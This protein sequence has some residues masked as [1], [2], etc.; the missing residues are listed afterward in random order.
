MSKKNTTSEKQSMMFGVE[1]CLAHLSEMGD[2]LEKV[3]ALMDW[4]MFRPLICKLVR[5]DDYSKGGRP[6]YDEI[7]MFKIILLQSWNNMSDDRTE[8][9]IN[10]RLDWIRFLGVQVGEKL[11]DSKTIWH[12]KE[13]LGDEGARELFDLFNKKLYDL[14]FISREGSMVDS[15]FV[16]VPRQRNT[17]EENEKI[18]NGEVSEEWLL[19]EKAHKLSQKD[20][21]ARWAKKGD[22]V[23]YGYKSHDKVDR[24]SKMVVDY[25][26]TSASA[27]DVTAFVGLVGGD[28]VAVW[29]DSAYSSREHEAQIREKNPGVV[30]HVCEKGTRGHTLTD[31]QRASNRVKSKVRCRVEHVFGYMSRFMGGISLR[32]IGLTRAR[33]GVGLMSLAYNIR[34]S[35]CILMKQAA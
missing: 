27:H 11:P 28:D 26:V 23:H 30:L 20:V 8:Y 22:E 13:R 15:T 9:L 5:K 31:E 1:I 25:T 4:E 34:R 16:D 19:P 14:G 18:K 29:A 6:P 10:C 3:E 35:V 17:R 21:D 2:S 24:D 32:T 33:R 7:L 12:F